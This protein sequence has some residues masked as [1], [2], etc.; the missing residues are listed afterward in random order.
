MKVLI[1]AQRGSKIRV[2]YNEIELIE[3]SR[4][5]LRK[6]YPYYYGFII[7]T[8]I[9]KEDCLDCF[10]ITDKKIEI[11]SIIECNPQDVFILYEG[12]EQDIK[13]IATLNSENEKYEIENCKSEIDVFLIEVF[14]EW[15]DV[16][17]TISK[18][19]G[20]KEAKMYIK[21]RMK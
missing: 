7:N 2:R 6:E 12:E 4:R 20:K 14:K 16:P 13:I 21:K 17:I 3:K 19:L 15:P 10:V 18:L 1:E 11:G 5:E 9:D 8:N